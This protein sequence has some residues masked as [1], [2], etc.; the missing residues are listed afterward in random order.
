MLA[1]DVVEHL[2]VS[3]PPQPPGHRSRYREHQHPP[4]DTS[5]ATGIVLGVAGRERFLHG[6][7][8]ACPLRRMP[9]FVQVTSMMAHPLTP[10][11]DKP[12]PNAA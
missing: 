9:R 5:P 7:V 8:H 2:R 1:V 11:R 12:E 10:T 3:E 6:G 4:R